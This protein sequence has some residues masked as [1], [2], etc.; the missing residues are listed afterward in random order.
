M[1]VGTCGLTNEGNRSISILIKSG[2]HQS[3]KRDLMILAFP[4]MI[5][6]IFVISDCSRIIFAVTIE[7]QFYLYSSRMK[8]LFPTPSAPLYNPLINI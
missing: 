7:K 5:G 3:S 1:P 4:L 2:S 6:M 8:I